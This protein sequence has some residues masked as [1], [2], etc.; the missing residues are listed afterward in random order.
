M[1]DLEKREDQKI[2]ECLQQAYGYSDEQL[3]KKMEEAEKSLEDTDFPGAEERI[4]QKLMERKA[5]EEEKEEREG[6]P[7]QMPEPIPSGVSISGG[8]APKRFGKRKL[9]ISAAL[10]AAFAVLLGI[11]AIGGRSYFLRERKNELNV[12]IINNNQNKKNI[13]QIEEAY[14][15]IET[16]L[17]IP[18][19]RLDYVPSN[20]EFQTSVQ[21]ENSVTIQFLYNGNIIILYEGKEADNISVGIESDRSQNKLVYNEWLDQEIAYLKNGL[22]DGRTEYETLLTIDENIYYFSGIMPEEEFV[23]IIKN[24]L[25]KPS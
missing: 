17:G 10:A 16:E 1:A 20:L 5:A 3:L 7:A 15:L 8:A 6:K 13:S 18:V 22:E 14:Q 9:A 19:L 4:F 24:F 11:T 25:F 2:R 12:T 23:K 21:K